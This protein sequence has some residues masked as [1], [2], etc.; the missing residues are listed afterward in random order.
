MILIVVLIVAFV[1]ENQ[2][3]VGVQ[4]LGWLMPKLP[5]SLYMLLSLLIGLAVG[6][7]FSWCASLRKYRG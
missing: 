5:V 6:P 4:F 7:L 3:L 1:L 2:E